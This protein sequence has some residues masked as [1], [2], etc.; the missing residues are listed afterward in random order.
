VGA[1]GDHGDGS[2][3]EKCVLPGEGA[4]EIDLVV[5]VPGRQEQCFDFSEL[6]ALVADSSDQD[7]RR[8]PLPNAA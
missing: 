7:D 6:S 3:S 5:I 4:T 8:N 2:L 1:G